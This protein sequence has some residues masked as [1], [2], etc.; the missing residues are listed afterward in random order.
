MGCAAEVPITEAIV[1]SPIRDSETYLALWT[2]AL[3]LKLRVGVLLPELSAELSRPNE[4]IPIPFP[5]RRPLR[6]SDVSACGT[7]LRFS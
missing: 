3:T 7:D 2:V 1:G 5:H 6:V 4:R